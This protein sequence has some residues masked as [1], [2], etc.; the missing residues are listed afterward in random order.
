MLGV[1]ASGGAGGIMG[2]LVGMGIPEYE[3][4]RYDGRIREG[5]VLLSVQYTDSNGK[6]RAEK[7]LDRTGAQD[8]SA[9][10]VVPDLTPKRKGARSRK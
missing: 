5:G 7:V 3:A 10:D 9:A 1:L 2:S 8:I 4:Q 6:E